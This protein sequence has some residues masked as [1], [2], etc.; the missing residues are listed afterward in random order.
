MDIHGHIDHPSPPTHANK[1]QAETAPVNGE[2]G[3]DPASPQ[4]PLGIKPQPTLDEDP[5]ECL[6]QENY[7]PVPGQYQENNR[8]QLADIPEL[9]EEDW[10]EGQF[11]NADLIDQHNT[12]H[13]SNRLRQE[14]SS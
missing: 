12:S 11:A 9:E 10:E 14:Y 6:P 7:K 8:Q 5:A 2:S 3:Q 4:D 1:I 13:E